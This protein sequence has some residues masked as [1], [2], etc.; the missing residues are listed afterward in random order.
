MTRSNKPNT[1]I[2]RHTYAG[3]VRLPAL[4]F[5]ADRDA[6]EAVQVW[7]AMPTGNNRQEMDLSLGRGKSPF[8]EERLSEDQAEAMALAFT[9]EPKDIVFED[10]V[11]LQALEDTA[12]N[13]Q[14]FNELFSIRDIGKDILVR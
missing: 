12:E 4:S 8:H 7:L 11:K 14:K 6:V 1:I 2:S 10:F 13:R 5:E 3:K 9:K